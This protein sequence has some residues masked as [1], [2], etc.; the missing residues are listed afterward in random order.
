MGANLALLASDRILKGMLLPRTPCGCFYVLRK[1][2]LDEGSDAVLSG[3][4]AVAH[5]RCKLSS[6]GLL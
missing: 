2:N 1:K 4:E 6:G 3:E 5:L